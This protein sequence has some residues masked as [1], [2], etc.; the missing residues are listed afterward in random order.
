MRGRRD[1]AFVPTDGLTLM[2]L[3][4]DGLTGFE[5]LGFSVNGLGP[6]FTAALLFDDLNHALSLG[7]T[8]V[9]VPAAVWLF[10]S[11]L[12]VLGWMRRKAA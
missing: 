1:Y 4:S 10:G 2:F 11:A 5:N 6:E 12:G 8:A 9:P 7:F 3:T